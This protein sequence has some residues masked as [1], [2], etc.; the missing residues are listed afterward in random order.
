M[1]KLLS[2]TLFISLILSPLAASVVT[3]D[4]E[5]TWQGTLEI[6]GQKLRLV[7][8]IHIGDKG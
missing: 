4:I 7:F 6:A 5:G 3:P 1:K 8:H 2:L